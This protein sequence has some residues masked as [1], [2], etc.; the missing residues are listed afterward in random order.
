MKRLFWFSVGVGVTVLVVWKA[1]DLMHKATPTGLQQQFV[2]TQH[3]AKN[4][5]AEFVETVQ[6]ASAEREIEIR[7]ALGLVEEVDEPAAKRGAAV[8]TVV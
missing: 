3:K 2:K 7:E 6:K 8:T 4:R 1:K 5:L